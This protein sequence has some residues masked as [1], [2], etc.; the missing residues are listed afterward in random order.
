MSK[1][2]ELAEIDINLFISTIK[3]PIIEEVA[4]PKI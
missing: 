4:T 1:T 3:K 2:S